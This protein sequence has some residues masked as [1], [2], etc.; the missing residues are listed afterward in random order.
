MLNNHS[1]ESDLGQWVQKHSSSLQ[2]LPNRVISY[3]SV[4]VGRSVPVIQTPKYLTFFTPTVFITFQYSTAIAQDPTNLYGS[5]YWSIG[6]SQ[7]P[8]V[9]PLQHFHFFSSNN[10]RHS[11]LLQNYCL[12]L[13]QCDATIRGSQEQDEE[14]VS[15]RISI[16]WT[17][18]YRSMRRNLT[19]LADRRM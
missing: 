4:T 5:S 17:I 8:K 1:T 9:D 11:I 12:R 7:Q 19:F 10:S 14:K 15:T 3:S 2:L 13:Q 18:M 6:Y 16:G